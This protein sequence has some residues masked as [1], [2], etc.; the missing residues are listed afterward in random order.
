MMATEARIRGGDSPFSETF[1]QQSGRLFSL[2]SLVDAPSK[3]AF[4]G[5]ATVACHIIFVECNTDIHGISG[6][7]QGLEVLPKESKPAALV[8]VS[9][10]A[11]HS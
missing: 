3:V 7:A 6:R 4:H 2:D 10:F 9:S 11:R 1:K 5:S 8:Q